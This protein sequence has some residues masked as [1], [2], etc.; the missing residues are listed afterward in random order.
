MYTFRIRAK[1]SELCGYA[2]MLIAV[3]LLGYTA[4][5]APK[6]QEQ[7]HSYYYGSSLKTEQGIDYYSGVD[8]ADD[9]YR[10]PDDMQ[11]LDGDRNLQVESALHGDRYR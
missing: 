10:L 3:A 11:R 9:N 2:I 7:W 6:P 1:S 5:C 4:A 8:A